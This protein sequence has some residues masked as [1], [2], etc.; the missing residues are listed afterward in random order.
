[1]EFDTLVKLVF[2][3]GTAIAI[4]AYFLYKDW[5]TTDQIIQTLQSIKEVLAELKTWHASEDK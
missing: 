1:M 5:K 3:H 2:E 4:I